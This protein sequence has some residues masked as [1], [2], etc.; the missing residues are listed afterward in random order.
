MRHFKVN[1]YCY[2]I[3]FNGLYCTI[4]TKLS[5]KYKVDSNPKNE[6]IIGTKRENTG[7]GLGL[8][9]APRDEKDEEEKRYRRR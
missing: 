5:I 6:R 2:Q 1:V 9:R 8:S 3:T 4:T 7:I